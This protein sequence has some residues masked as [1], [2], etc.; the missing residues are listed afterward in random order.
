ML[1]RT[2]LFVDF[3]GFS[4]EANV[5]SKGFLVFLAFIF[6]FASFFPRTFSFWFLGSDLRDLV[7]KQDR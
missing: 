1:W 3:W 6:F 4:D 5:W 7:I 2:W